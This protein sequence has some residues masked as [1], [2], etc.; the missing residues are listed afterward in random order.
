V[1]VYEGCAIVFPGS[2]R[3]S[4]LALFLVSVGAFE[5]G[6]QASKPCPRTRPHEQIIDESLFG[7]A[8]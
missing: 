7:D 3:D 5:K 1:C 6:T 8:L 2:K 4:S